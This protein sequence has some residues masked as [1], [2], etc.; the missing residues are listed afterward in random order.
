MLMGSA[1]ASQLY[2]N[3]DA[4]EVTCYGSLPCVARKIFGFKGSNPLW[5]PVKLLPVAI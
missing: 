5:Y 2:K 3:G 1:D 4:D